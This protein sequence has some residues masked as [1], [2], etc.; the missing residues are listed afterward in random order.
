M[1]DFL[2]IAGFPDSLLQ[3]REQL[4]DALL[5]KGFKIHVAAPNL[6]PECC[7]RRQLVA[8][9]LVVHDIPL[10]R[11]G[12]SP[13]DDMKTFIYLF[14]LIHC[15]RPSFV[16]SY[17]I[18]PVIYGTLSAALAGVP[19]R[20]A[21]IT[22]LGYAFQHDDNWGISPRSVI[23]SLVRVL[24]RWSLKNAHVVFFQNPDD[25]ALFR[26]LGILSPATRSVVVN[27]SGVDI[28]QYALCPI[29]AGRLGR[30]QPSS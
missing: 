26:S 6:P 16:L 1:Q 9:G 7:L 10:H 2:L 21:L 5:A 28:R 4:I 19:S 3:F 27:G 23:R 18:K 20:Y 12:T 25:Q 15:I 13:Y 29:P 17:T 22:G 8:K 14:R 24:Y 30:L 11:T